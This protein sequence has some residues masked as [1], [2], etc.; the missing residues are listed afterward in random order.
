VRCVAN[1]L[2]DARINV[3]QINEAGGKHIA[4][5]GWRDGK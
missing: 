5:T 1:V 4:S 2:G 3:T